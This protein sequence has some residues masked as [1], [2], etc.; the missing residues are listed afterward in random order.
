M[1]E[2]ELLEFLYQT[3]VGVIKTD[4]DG[5]V[6]IL[7]P[8]A[9]NILMTVNPDFQGEIPNIFELFSIYDKYF[10]E[11]II[12]KIEKNDKVVFENYDIEINKFNL[13]KLRIQCVKLAS[14]NLAFVIEDIS[15]LI[16]LEE[17]N[18][19]IEK[20]LTYQEQKLIKIGQAIRSVIHDLRNPIG[21]IQIISDMSDFTTPDELKDLF[22]STIKT[23]LGEINSLMQDLLDY[24]K[25]ESL[26][27]EEVSIETLVDHL[28]IKFDYFTK[29]YKIPFE[30]KYQK[31]ATIKCDEQK[32]IRVFN[33]ICSNAVKALSKMKLDYPLIEVNILK[34]KDKT[35]IS[36]SDNGTGIPV[37]LL[38]KMFDPFAFKSD[39]VGN[40]IGLSIVKNI[41][42]MHKGTIDVNSSKKGT[43]FTIVF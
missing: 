12:D 15:K 27:L 39:Y 6:E 23:V 41:I 42:D 26:K 14:N 18:K 13:K 16:E 21:N 34:E 37:D 5:V 28:K 1:N 24:S 35:K 32:I 2:D 25:A 3:P 4:L 36:I 11:K 17:K 30:I 10:T 19:F 22:D 33:N 20:Q 38:E 7:N 29:E 9:T 43:L 8:K 31:N 40:G